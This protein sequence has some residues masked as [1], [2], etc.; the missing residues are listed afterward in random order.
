MCLQ[1]RPAGLLLFGAATVAP[2][3]G[4]FGLKCHSARRICVELDLKGR[5]L[6]CW[7]LICTELWIFVVL[8]FFFLLFE[9]TEL[10]IPLTCCVFPLL[11]ATFAYEFGCHCL[12]FPFCPSCLHCCRCLKIYIAVCRVNGFLCVIA[13][14][15]C[16]K[17]PNVN[18]L[19][20][21]R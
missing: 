3:T 1:F 19:E 6:C 20:M 16:Q 12:V 8:V 7:I 21:K 5:D 11:M 10:L 2:W 9:Q 13:K 15:L 18:L 4:R 14:K 17:N